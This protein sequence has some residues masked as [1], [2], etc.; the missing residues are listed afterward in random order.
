MIRSLNGILATC[1]VNLKYVLKIY[2]MDLFNNIS[3]I[4]D[5]LVENVNSEQWGSN[6]GS[7]IY[8]CSSYRTFSKMS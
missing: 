5:G 2:K 4:F 3:M 6:K 8:L 7:L 1:Y